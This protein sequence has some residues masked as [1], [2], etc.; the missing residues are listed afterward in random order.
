MWV[1]WALGSYVQSVLKGKVLTKEV[2][3]TQEQPWSCFPGCTSSEERAPFYDLSI[4]RATKTPN[5]QAPECPSAKEGKRR[6]AAEF[7]QW[8][9]ERG[10]PTLVGTADGK[11]SYLR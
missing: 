8:E 10:Q 1:C 9:G 2:S 6:G 7:E 5:M 3:G 11:D 4:W